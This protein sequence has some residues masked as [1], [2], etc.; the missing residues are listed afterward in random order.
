MVLQSAAARIGCF[1]P[2]AKFLQCRGP[3][4]PV[5]NGVGRKR[6]GLLQSGDSFRG[7]ASFQGHGPETVPCYAVLRRE[8]NQRLAGGLRFVPPAA[9]AQLVNLPTE[10][11]DLF[12]VAHA[13]TQ[14]TLWWHSTCCLTQQMILRTP[15]SLG[16]DFYR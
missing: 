2:A 14:R 12:V 6:H 11:M 9:L 10:I 3:F 15:L 8:L 16:H 5:L 7:R 1:L 4:T 13:R